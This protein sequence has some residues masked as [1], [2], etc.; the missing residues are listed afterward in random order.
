VR[1]A[2]LLK[3]GKLTDDEFVI[4]K[5]HAEYGHEALLITEQKLG[6]STF[7]R[8]A[9]EIAYTH[10]EKWDGS[11]YP[12]G[13]RGEEI[14]VSGRLMALADVYDALISKRVYKPPMPHEKAVQIISEGRGRHFDPDVVDAFLQLEAVFRNIA[15]TFADYEEE[16]R[17]LGGGSAPAGGAAPRKVL[18]VDDN[19][20]NL[21]IMSSQLVARGYLVDVASSGREAL[22][23]HRPGG[24][25]LILTDLDMPA[26]D[27]YALAAELRRREE[28]GTARPTPIFAITASEF[29]LSEAGARA[30]G[31]SGHMLKPLDP[32][33]LDRKLQGA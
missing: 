1:D 18:L 15:L 33:L 11:G 13:L 24:Y 14:P 7:L 6:K 30:H 32:D 27:G 2:V 8:H 28:G 17:A 26:M 29:D 19:P 21:E 31:F 12:R 25:D 3:N 20:I 9:R 22:E 5:K 4:M 10:Q 23:L 16:R